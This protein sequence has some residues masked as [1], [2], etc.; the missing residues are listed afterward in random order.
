MIVHLNGTTAITKKTIMKKLLLFLTGLTMSFVSM[1]QSSPFKAKGLILDENAEPLPFST[2]LLMQTA[3]SVLVKASTTE[4]DGKFT[5]SEI[6]EGQYFLQISMVGYETY[7]SPSFFLNSN[8]PLFELKNLKLQVQTNTLEQVEVVAK[9]PFIEQQLDKTVVNV[10]NSIVASGNTLLEVLE[11]SPGVVVDRQNNSLQLKGKNGVQVMIDGRPNFLSQEALMQ[12]LENTNSE[13]VATI[14]LITNPSSKYDA[15]GNAGIINIKLKRNRAFGTNGS[16][17][18]TA[19]DVFLPNSTNDLYRGSTN[20]SLNHRQ[21]KFN[22]FGNINLGRNAFYNDNTLLRVTN[23]DGLQTNFDQLSQR[24]GKGLYTN[25]RTGIDFFLSEKTTLGFMG[26]VNNWNGTMQSVGLTQISETFSD[27][28]TRSSLIPLSDRSNSNLNYAANINLKHNFNDKGKEMTFDADYSGFRNRANQNFENTFY[29]REGNITQLL[30]QRNNTPTDVDIWAA[31]VDFTIPTENKTKLEFGAK[32]SYVQTDNDFV[33]EQNIDNAWVNDE[34][35]TNHFI[36]SEFVN[37]AYINVGHQWEKIGLQSGLR[38]EHT[39]SE[40]NSIT[41]NKIVPR[42]YLSIFPTLF[43]NHKLSEKHALRYS[44]SRRIGRPNYQQL[45]PFIFFLDPFTF[46]RG[47]AFLN[48]QFTENTEVTYSFKN[49]VSLSLG[50]AYIKDNM[51]DIIEQDDASRVTFQTETNL[52]K[53]ENL[54]AN[55]SFPIPVTKWWLMQNNVSAYYNRFR[56]SDVSGG[57]LDVGQFAYNFYTSS[58]FTLKKGW[59]AQANMWYNSPNV[60]GIIRSTKP[61]YA[62]N[63]GIQKTVLDKKGTIKLNA[64]D[65]FLTSFFNGSIDYEN[66]DLDVTNRWAS[67]TVNLS[68]TYNFGNQN[69]K[70]SRRRDT[71]AQDLRQRAEK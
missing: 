61:Q 35:K 33:F 18:V 23:Y 10:E 45:N 27:V 37:A 56:D 70:A 1:A 7:R 11:K 31:K 2:V 67:R 14:E 21:E 36:Y 46:Q 8:T 15:Q 68:F 57:Q 9:K 5:L 58:V 3:D 64:N 44:Y 13:E 60:F 47:N 65:L 43:I 25:A 29:N 19:G 30:L 40:G 22:V 50:Y 48:P 62:V 6:N 32:S 20:L 63:I 42:S 24:W 52:E 51:F 53:T 66:I 59:S 28:N 69:V 49:A 17:T 41:L 34:G 12:L 4:L 55:L 38:A 71:A 54:S 39:I 16:I 26:D